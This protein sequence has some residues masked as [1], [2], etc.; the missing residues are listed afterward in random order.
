MGAS[1]YE[2][3]GFR[4]GWFIV[5][6]VIMAALVSGATALATSDKCGA[7]SSAKHWQYFPPHWVCG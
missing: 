1:S 5:V 7:Y 4:L 2:K 3:S 6:L